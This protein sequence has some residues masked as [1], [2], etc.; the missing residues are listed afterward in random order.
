MTDSN[1][2]RT[3]NKD[4]MNFLNEIAMDYPSAISFASGRP[5]EKYFDFDGLNEKLDLFIKYYSNNNNINEKRARQL[6]AQYGRTRGLINE[7]ISKQVWRDESI[8]CDE[9]RIVITSG[10]QEAMLICLKLLFKSDSDVLVVFNPTYIGITGLAELNS[11]DVEYISI[12]D[13]NDI[14]CQL[15]AIN[16]KLKKKGKRIRAI[17]VIPDFDN[18]T[19]HVLSK[20]DRKELL[21]YCSQEKVYIMEDNP[22]GMFRYN[23]ETIPSLFQTDCDGCVLY[24]GTYAKTLY[25]SI[26]LGYVLV[27]A[28]IFGRK[29]HVC[30]VVS[31]LSKIKS[32]TTV[33]TSQLLQAVVGG[34]LLDNDFSLRN[35]IEPLISHY[36]KNRDIMLAALSRY[37]SDVD[38]LISWNSPEGGFFLVVKLPFKFTKIEAEQ[39]ARIYNVL[40]MPLSF[41]SQNDDF[42]FHVR[43]SFSC[44]EP[45][46]IERGIGFFSEFVHKKITGMGLVSDGDVM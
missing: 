31:D 7:F 3:S 37:F 21:Q 24:L 29:D 32:F 43:L 44:E 28:T 36:R 12:F 8:D 23:N 11:I 10:C 17:Y 26:R 38:N 39:C 27:P 9:E 46:N 2:E 35:S 6:V 30:D 33:N 15:E 22:Y 45:R 19:G 25:P 16:L 41:F 34:T 42:D 40:C 20:G 18:P 14:C 1:Q 5:S 13:E 4:V